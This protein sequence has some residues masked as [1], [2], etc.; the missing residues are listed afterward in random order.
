MYSRSSLKFFAKIVELLSNFSVFVIFLSFK[1]KKK[2]KK[3]KHGSFVV[4]NQQHFF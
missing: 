2:K 4:Y 3:K 1:K